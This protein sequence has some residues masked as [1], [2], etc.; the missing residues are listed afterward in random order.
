MDERLE[1]G[2]ASL[3]ASATPPEVAPVEPE[4]VEAPAPDARQP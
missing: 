3:N 1:A 2:L 4:V